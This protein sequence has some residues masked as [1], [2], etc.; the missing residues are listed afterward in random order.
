MFMTIWDSS[1][2]TI[3]WEGMQELSY[4]YDTITERPVSFRQAVEE[5][6][7]EIIKLLPVEGG[8]VYP[9]VAKKDTP[10]PE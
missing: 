10:N 6:T 1:D 2:G 8:E 3:A 4:A 9:S 7:L 5:A